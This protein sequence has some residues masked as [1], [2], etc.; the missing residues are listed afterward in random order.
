MTYSILDLIKDLEETNH[1]MDWT[2]PKEG[3]MPMAAR[4]LKSFLVCHTECVK[5]AQGNP[6]VRYNEAIDDAILCLI[7][8]EGAIFV[9]GKPVENVGITTS[10]MALAIQ[11][12]IDK[13]AEGEL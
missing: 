12:Y 2:S 1:A 9:D 10:S 13:I 11:A 6:L 4:T 8:S 7:R 5:D 3:L